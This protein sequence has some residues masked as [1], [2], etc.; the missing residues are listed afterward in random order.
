LAPPGAVQDQ[1][2]EESLRIIAPTLRLTQSEQQ[3]LLPLVRLARYAS[4]EYV[5]IAG[6]VPKKMTFI[7]NGHVQLMVTGDEGVLIPV[8]TLEQG[9]FLGSTT[10]TRE[11]VATTAYAL[12]EVTVL[13]MDR[14]HIEE[15]VRRKPLLL[16]DIGRT[17]EQRRASVKRALAATAD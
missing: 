2:L 15:L 3:E 7:V 17:I 13:Q 8:R 4:E 14:E 5:Q 11:P 6:N 1:R 10:L 16:Q 12:E 9:D